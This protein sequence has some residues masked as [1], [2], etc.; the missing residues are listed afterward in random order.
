MPGTSTQAASAC[1]AESI[2]TIEAPP[3]VDDQRTQKVLV[4]DDIEINRRVLSAI[5]RGERCTVLMAEDGNRAFE[6]ATREQPD[7]ILLDIM[8]PG[9]DGFEVCAELKA[10]P[11]TRH[12]PVIFL[13]ALSE[14][15]N[16]IKGLGL[17]AVDYIT[18][19]FD[20]AEVLARVRSHLRIQGLTRELIATNRELMAKQQSLD[21]DLRAAGDIQS[22]LIP[23]GAPS[24]D[25][26]HVA[27]RFMPCDRIGGDV[28]NLYR[29]D[30]T[31]L[32]AY[33]VD[34]S[35]HGVPAAM[36]TVSVS[37]SLSPLAGCIVE[38]DGQSQSGS[39]IASP[40]EVLRRLDAEYPIERF[41][42]FFTICYLVLNY[43]TGRLR[44]SRA[45][46]P[47]PVLV[48]ADGTLSS[49]AAGGSIIGLGAGLAFDEDEIELCRG[50][51]LFLYTDGIVEFANAA[52]GFYGEERLHAALIQGRGESLEHVCERV[53]TS[54]TDFGDGCTPQDDVT[55]VAIEFAGPAPGGMG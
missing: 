7:L 46:H 28:F 33:V 23:K 32:A 52:G 18:K 8:M 54:M 29:L 31:H 37:Q 16:K 44:Y 14:Q 27:W 19:P 24:V 42:K 17:G 50:D 30:D 43:R 55:L 22:S 5:L 2:E 1:T 49:L 45:G 20:K 39:T 35:G 10:D 9:K 21:A 36:V 47:M 13:S 3:P 51:R 41:D 38:G 4:V 40:G 26:V 25:A 6:T 11:R 48:R 53:V 34:V 12:V 15:A